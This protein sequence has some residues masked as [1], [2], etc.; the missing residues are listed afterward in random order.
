MKTNNDI[1]FM[2]LALT[3]AK[4]A[5]IRGD[6][7]IGAVLVIDGKII[8]KTNNALFSKSS[9]GDHAETQL[10]LKYSQMI[11]KAKKENKSQIDLYTTLE[12]CLMCLGCATLHRVDRIIYSCPDPR[13]GATKVDIS[14]L[15]SFYK[16][17][18]PKI[19]TDLLKEESY[20]MLIKF[21]EA[22]TIPQ[23]KINKGLFEKMA[24]KWKN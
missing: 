12:P 21:M 5:L 7:P 8:E 3:E 6:I 4:K 19:E 10:I 2:K 20:L 22:S 14:N 17:H 11:K 15:P 23:W 16:D 1:K 9:W 13:G 24:E 18:W